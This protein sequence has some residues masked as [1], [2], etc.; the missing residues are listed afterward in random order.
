[1]AEC[2]ARMGHSLDTLLGY[3]GVTGVHRLDAALWIFGASILL[4]VCFAIPA[5]LRTAQ[6]GGAPRRQR[7]H[8]MTAVET[9]YERGIYDDRV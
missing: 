9:G 8:S 3:L 2:F 6:L 7:R 4:W 5:V 1:M